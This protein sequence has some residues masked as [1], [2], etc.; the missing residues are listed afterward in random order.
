MRRP[1]P[2]RKVFPD[3]PHWGLLFL[4]ALASWPP[5]AWALDAVSG[6]DVFGLPFGQLLGSGLICLWGSMARTNQR[7][8]AAKEAEEKFELWLEVWRDA[9][10]SSVIGA[11]VYIMAT[12]QGWDV[13]RLGGALLFAGYLG[14]AALDLWAA[15]FKGNQD[16]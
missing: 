9:R 1:M 2:A 4:L 13:W 6:L 10:R 16:V 15:K 7:A 11:V 3:K 8:R 5:A 14:P 12:M